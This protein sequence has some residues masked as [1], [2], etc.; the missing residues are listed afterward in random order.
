MTGDILKKEGKKLVASIKKEIKD[1]G[2]VDTG[3]ALKSVTSKATKDTL[4]IQW[5]DYASTLVLG[6]GPGKRPP[7]D[8]IKN[9]VIRKLNP[10]EEMVWAITDR[11]CKKIEAE[12][13][14]IYRNKN[15]GLAVTVIINEAIEI[16]KEAV[17]KQYKE[18][19]KQQIK[20]AWH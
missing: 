3:N 7:F 18:N 20:K 5:A 16:I 12:G 2:L 8:L 14:A 15:K 6:R 17:A 9:W 1:K 10:P 13:T 4:S 19:I 11:I